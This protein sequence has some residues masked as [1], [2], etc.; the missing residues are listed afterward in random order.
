MFPINLCGRDHFTFL[1]GCL[2]GLDSIFIDSTNSN[3]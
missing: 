1:V 2:S 3:W